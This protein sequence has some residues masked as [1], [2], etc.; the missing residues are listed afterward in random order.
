[1]TPG[2]ALI[3]SGEKTFS[4]AFPF[5]QTCLRK[6]AARARRWGKPVETI[7]IHPWDATSIILPHPA[8]PYARCAALVRR[9]REIPHQR[10]YR[11]TRPPWMTVRR[12][13]IICDGSTMPVVRNSNEV[14]VENR[15]CRRPRKT[16]VRRSPLVF[17]SEV[18]GC[19][20]VGKPVETHRVYPCGVILSSCPAL[21][22]SH[23]PCWTP[24]STRGTASEQELRP[25][26]PCVGAP[27]SATVK[28]KN[29]HL[30]YDLPLAPEEIAPLT[31]SPTVGFPKA[32]L[33]LLVGS[34]CPVN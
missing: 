14:L 31:L 19:W 12:T 25:N 13:R 20:H 18:R 26:G 30:F 11:R 32:A 21:H 8:P 16:S 15:V 23:A 3:F 6:W 17:I 28:K 5:W 2:S 29:V 22:P 4:L 9:A 27:L 10:P 24:R 1:M 33:A 7:L 34:T